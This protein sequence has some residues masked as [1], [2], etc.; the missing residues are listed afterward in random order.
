MFAQNNLDKNIYL[1]NGKEL[2][3][4]FFENYDYGTRFYDPQIGRWHSVD[5]LAEKSR[6]WSPYNYCVDN[7]IRFIDPDGMELTDFYNLYGIKVKHVEDGKTDRKMVLTTSKNEAKVNQTIDKGFVVTAFSNSESAKMGDIYKTASAD[8]T[9]TEQG[10]MRGTNGE[11]KVV[12]GTIAGEVSPK[13]WAEAKSDLTAKGSTPISDVHLHPNEFDASGNMTGYGK[14][15]GSPMDVLPQNNRGYT[16][17]SVVLGYKPEIQPLPT[18]QIGGTPQVN[19]VP[20]VGF[21]DTKNNPI[22]TIPFSDLQSAIKKINQ[23]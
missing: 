9:K 13:Q 17:P 2:N 19:Y 23:R 16:E 10:F 18:G 22:V 7:P 4:E 12:T 8:K 1:Y 20:T 14:P 15:E 5:P 11:S 6:R 21:Y 3:N